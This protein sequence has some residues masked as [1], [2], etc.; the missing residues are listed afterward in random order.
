MQITYNQNSTVICGPG[1]FKWIDFRPFDKVAG[2]V[3]YH[4]SL[5]QGH[6]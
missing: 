3:G 5:R 6:L 2:S 4:T 1:S